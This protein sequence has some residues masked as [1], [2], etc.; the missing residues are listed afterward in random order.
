MDKETL[1]RYRDNQKEVVQIKEQIETIRA[2]L[3][4]PKTQ[5]LTGMPS[6]HGDGDPLTDGIAAIDSLLERYEK[7]LCSLCAEQEKIER[8]LEL[9]SGKERAILRYRYICGYKWETIC[10]LMG[11]EK[12]GPMEWTTIH[13]KHRE[14]LRRLQELTES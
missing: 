4:A 10:S 9:L 3:E 14:A 2:R 6:G 13:R 12:Y 7:K 5:M 8:A 11:S 1:M